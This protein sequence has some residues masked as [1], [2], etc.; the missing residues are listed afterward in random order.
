M[1]VMIFQRC[2]MHSECLDP[3]FLSK[4]I[5]DMLHSFSMF[6]IWY[7]C[8]YEGF[9][10]KYQKPPT[11]VV[12]KFQFSSSQTK[13]ISSGNMK[14]MFTSKFKCY[15]LSIRAVKKAKKNMDSF[16]SPLLQDPTVQ[17]LKSPFLFHN[18]QLH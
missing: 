16:R 17:S 1:S 13:V 2:N 10:P 6:H 12:Q 4:L 8:T 11:S 7:T 15:N 3:Y 18:F 5:L 9:L 14:K